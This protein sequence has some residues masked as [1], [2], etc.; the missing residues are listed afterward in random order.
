M[1]TDPFAQQNRVGLTTAYTPQFDDVVHNLQVMFKSITPAMW[2]LVAGVCGLLGLAE[3]VQTAGIILFASV[4]VLSFVAAPVL[5]FLEFVVILICGGVLFS[6][7]APLKLRMLGIT[8]GDQTIAE[9]IDAMKPVFLYSLGSYT[10]L[11]FGTMIGSLFCI[12]P[13]FLAHGVLCLAPYYSSQGTSPITAAQDSF[14]TAKNHIP[15]VAM[16]TGILIF[17]G[18]FSFGFTL[19]VASLLGGGTIQLIISKVLAILV[20]CAMFLLGWF[21]VGS[22]SLTIDTAQTGERVKA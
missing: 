20:Q 19:G 21:A 7:F 5:N 1:E 2:T 3:I 11:V 6:L 9:L 22:V 14:E 15:L 16:A 8:Q 4:P 13:G 12:I 10:I 18:L 17:A